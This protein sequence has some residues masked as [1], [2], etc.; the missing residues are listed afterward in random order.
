[1]ATR[2]I[3]VRQALL[4]VIVS[5]AVPLIALAVML[6]RQSLTTERNA[7]TNGHLAAARSLA[8]LVENEI[9]THVALAATLAVSRALETGDLGDFHRQAIAVT[10]KAL[11]T[12]IA[13]SDR[14]GKMLLSSLRPFGDALPAREASAPA[15][16]AVLSSRSPYLT[17]V[18][19]GEVSGRQVAILEYPVIIDGEVA[20][21]I[22]VV[23]HPENFRRLLAEKFGREAAVAVIDRQ[24]RFVAR[25]PDHE[26]RVGTPAAFTWRQAIERSP[27]EGFAETVTLE[28][29][30]SLTSYAATRHGWI[31]GISYPLASLYA[32]VTRQLWLMVSLGG[33]LVLLAIV[34]AYVIARRIT[35]PAA[36]LVE[37]ARHLAEGKVV[38]ATRFGV[39]EADEISEAI[40]QSSRLLRQRLDDLDLAQRHQ[41]FLLREL[42]HRLKNQLTVINSMARQTARSSDSAEAMAESLARRI[43]GLAVGV[44]LLVSQNW[45]EVPLEALVRSQLAPFLPE[46]DRLRIEGPEV[47][48]PPDLTQSVGLALHELATNALKYGAWS[49]PE[50]LV[51]CT[52]SL[53]EAGDAQAMTFL[54]K[55]TG[56]PPCPAPTRR[57]FGRVVIEQAAGRGQGASSVLDF[58]PDGLR[59]AMTVK[60]AA[61]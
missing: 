48:L 51:R 42:A 26:A 20:Y 45:R 43:Q 29:V 33:T 60:F 1:M 19:Q 52:W 9:E 53:V 24:R 12:W 56:G 15:S 21:T 59:W 34:I 5:V 8:A 6:M 57:G 37:D 41:G 58:E 35:T 16:A 3:S 14:S 11:P 28:G 10:Q 55:E 50:G 22:S 13:L 17:D 25:I 46:D 61:I 44:D 2:S 38:G 32:P 36:V 4:G 7:I 30:P 54:W 39:R 23:L 18:L 31:A 47:Q 27:Q 49:V 40:S